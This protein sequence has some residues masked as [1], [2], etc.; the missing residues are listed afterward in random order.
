MGIQFCPI[1]I[2]FRSSA[3]GQASQG[4]Q[5]VLFTSGSLIILCLKLDG[6]LGKSA[7]SAGRDASLAVLPDLTGGFLVLAQHLAEIRRA[8]LALCGVVSNN[9]DS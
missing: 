1:S 3:L 4:S 5:G 6:G 9:I 8:S 2:A 7:T